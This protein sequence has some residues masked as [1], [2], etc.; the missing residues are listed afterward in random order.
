MGVIKLEESSNL[1]FLCSGSGDS[2]EVATGR[3]PRSKAGDPSSNTSTGN[4]YFC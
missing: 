4:K 2:S 1:Q 3:T